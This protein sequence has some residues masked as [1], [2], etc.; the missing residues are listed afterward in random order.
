MARIR[1]FVQTHPF[2]VAWALLAVGM[3]A[4][5]LW[6]SSD[7]H[8]LPNQLAFLVFTTILLAG[9][10]VWIISWEEPLTGDQ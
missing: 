9:A 6:T 2:L 5:L 3:V 7:A 10:C 1:R 8:L 4:I